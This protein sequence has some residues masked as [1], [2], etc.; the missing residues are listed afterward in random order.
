[1][2]GLHCCMGF[3][4]VALSGVHGFFIA[5]ASL[6]EHGLQGAQASVVVAHGL[7]CPAARGIFPHQGSN[8]RPQHWQE[9]SLLL[10][11][12][13]S[14]WTEFLMLFWI[15]QNYV[16]MATYGLVATADGTGRSYQLEQYNKNV[17][18][19]LLVFTSLRKYL[20]CRENFALLLFREILWK[21]ICGKVLLLRANYFSRVVELFLFL[22]IRKN[23]ECCQFSFICHTKWPTSLVSS[24]AVLS[25]T[26]LHWLYPHFS[27]FIWRC[28]RRPI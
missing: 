26:K 25:L 16:S 27:L 21:H 10:S 5:V 13:G 11:H 22:E 7:S 1:M 20:H 2:L 18:E 14:P 8:P 6:V 12:Q 23:G 15:I 17:S 9:D 28:P 19:G 3:S 24:S 4:L